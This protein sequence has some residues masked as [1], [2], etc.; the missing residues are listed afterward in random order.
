VET[1]N[2]A[3]DVVEV[4]AGAEARLGAVISVM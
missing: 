2:A 3:D 4:P 1:A